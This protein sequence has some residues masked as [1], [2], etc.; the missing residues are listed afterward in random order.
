M[1]N[2][3]TSIL[4]LMVFC[5][6]KDMITIPPTNSNL[7]SVAKFIGIK[8]SKDLLTR[9]EVIALTRTIL[10]TDGRLQRQRHVT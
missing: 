3:K 2:N 8:I 10:S 9:T 4:P 7:Y 6:E 5:L 1:Y